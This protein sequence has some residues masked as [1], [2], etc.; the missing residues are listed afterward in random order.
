M[1]LQP[2]E[3]STSNNPESGALKKMYS[4]TTIQAQLTSIKLLAMMHIINLIVRL[5]VKRV[6]LNNSILIERN[7]LGGKM[8][9][10]VTLAVERDSLL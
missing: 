9:L 1:K 6:F 8:A 10:E 7:I 5:P 2:G 3:A 4:N